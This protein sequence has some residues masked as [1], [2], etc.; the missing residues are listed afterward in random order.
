MIYRL[1]SKRLAQSTKMSLP[2]KLWDDSETRF[3]DTAETQDFEFINDTREGLVERDESPKYKNGSIL[4]HHAT[5]D[6]PST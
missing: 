3:L 4:V 6:Y 1:N 2:I 5:E